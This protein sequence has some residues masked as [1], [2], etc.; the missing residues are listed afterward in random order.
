MN[1][2]HNNI[3]LLLYATMLTLKQY[4]FHPDTPNIPKLPYSVMTPTAQA[5]RRAHE[6]KQAQLIRNTY[7]PLSLQQFRDMQKH[8]KQNTH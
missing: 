8:K 4:S 7:K 1:T 5:A 2:A 3:C 6:E